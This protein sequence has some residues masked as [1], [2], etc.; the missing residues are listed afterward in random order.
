MLQWKKREGGFVGMAAPIIF[1]TKGP[2]HYR[3]THDFFE[4]KNICI[5]TFLGEDDEQCRRIIEQQVREG[6]RVVITFDYLSDQLSGFFSVPFAVIRRSPSTII[7]ILMETLRTESKVALI[8]H[9]K[10]SADSYYVR[11]M[12]E[13][14]EIFP[15]S[16]VLFGFRRYDEAAQTLETICEKGFHTVIGPHNLEQQ[17]RAMGLDY[18]TVPLAESDLTDAVEQAE[19]HLR[20]YEQ[21][22]KNESLINAILDQ[23]DQGAVAL[24]SAGH[25]LHINSTA[26]SLFSLLK[27][28][29]I[30]AHYTDTPL[31]SIEAIAE[32]QKTKKPVKS[33][34]TLD[35]SVLV[36]SVTPLLVDGTLSNIIL[37]CEL[38]DRIQEKDINVRNKLLSNHRQTGKTFR[39]IV[40]SSETM[41]RTVAM[42][43]RYAYYDS[44]IL[45]SAPSGCGKEVFAQSI[46]HASRRKDKPFVVINCAALPESILESLLFGYEPGTF[47][48]AKAGGKAGLFELAHGG[49]VF[50]DE[51]SEMPLMM[52]SRFLRVI[53]E[54]EVLRIGSDRP[55]PVD[56]RI[57]AATNRDL[58]KMVQEH[59]FRED[60]YHRISVLLL[61]IPPLD[62]RKEDIEQLSRYFLSE[63]SIQL[64]IPTPVLTDDAVAFLR[65]QSYRGNV[66]Q[67]NNILE[68]A[69]IL[70]PSPRIDAADLALAVGSSAQTAAASS[71]RV[72]EPSTLSDSKSHSEADAIRYALEKFGGNRQ[73]MAAY[74]GVSTTTLWRKMRQYGLLEPSGGSVNGG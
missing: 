41:S 23:L 4:K 63:R 19:Y 60:L 2:H 66:R 70:A 22:I 44:T 12:R 37:S 69:M 40:G 61:E 58:W 43:K 24:D 10:E 74:L 28:D 73:Q 29:P 64:R 62:E 51:I 18:R 7:K 55:I 47:T 54:R 21:H 49:T 30:G 16:T 36:C 67:L 14:A 26:R 38:A 56:I 35:G 9:D 45:I 32:A 15:D 34:V 13:A 65:A 57:I 39:A 50:L 11:S 52:Q 5:P 68:R 33:I 53:Q 17:A 25:I 1:V 27:R 71:P 31:G 42:A 72:Q 46:H 20:L 6:S 8:Y 48:G 3:F 59:A